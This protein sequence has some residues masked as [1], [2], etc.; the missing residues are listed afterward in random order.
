M[1]SDTAKLGRT[2]SERNY[3]KEMGSDAAKLGR[4]ESER[5]YMSTRWGVMQLS[6]VMGRRT[7]DHISNLVRGKTRAD[8]K[9]VDP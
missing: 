5:N 3:V 6:S 4:M 2:E 9:I 8:S 1:G 7:S